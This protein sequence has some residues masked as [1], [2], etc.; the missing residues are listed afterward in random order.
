MITES[1]KLAE[2]GGAKWIIHAAG[3]IWKLT[4]VFFDNKF[5]QIMD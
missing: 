2:K 1:C 4:K 3:P 5:S